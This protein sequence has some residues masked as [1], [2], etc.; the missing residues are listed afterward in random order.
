MK[1]R[2]QLAVLMVAQVEAHSLSSALSPYC[3]KQRDNMT[4][5]PSLSL[6][7][8]QRICNCIDKV[9]PMSIECTFYSMG[10]ITVQFTLRFVYKKL[11]IGC[12]ILNR[13]VHILTRTGRS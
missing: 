11:T 2:V 5:V 1:E 10:F 3:E 7:L 12:T 9:G 6:A 13:R 8:F 4:T